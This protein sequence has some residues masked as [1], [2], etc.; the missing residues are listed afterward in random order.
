[1]SAA[2]DWLLLVVERHAVDRR[3]LGSL[4]FVVVVRVFPS[5]ATTM[6]WVTVSLPSYLTTILT[7]FGSTPGDRDRVTVWAVPVI[8]VSLPSYFAVNV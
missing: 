1:M 7:V 3:A 8:G 6:V 5:G 4:P 2:A